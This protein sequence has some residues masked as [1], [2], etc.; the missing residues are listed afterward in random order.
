MDIIRSRKRFIQ[1]ITPSKKKT[2][3]YKI[4]KN[5]QRQKLNDNI[6]LEFAIFMAR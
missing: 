5:I 3:N 6:F 4:T 2:Y 1:K